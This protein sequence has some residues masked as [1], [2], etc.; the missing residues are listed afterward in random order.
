MTT[1]PDKGIKNIIIKKDLLGK[2]TSSNGIV[3]RF[4]IVSEDKN[5]KSPYSQIFITQSGDVLL[6]TGDINQVGNTI[7]VNWSLS[8]ANPTAQSL[9]DIFVGFDSATPTYQASTSLQ[10][11]SFLKTGTASVRV[12]I[13]T[14]SINPAINDDLTIYDSQTVSLV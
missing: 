7:I 6:G 9:Y 8:A 12:I 11:Y 13:Q 3:F 2:V 4:R 14:S 5:R 10:N 1:K